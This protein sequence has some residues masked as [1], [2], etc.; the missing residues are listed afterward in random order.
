[1]CNRPFYPAGFAV[2]ALLCSQ[3][4]PA[5]SKYRHIALPR[6]AFVAAAA[7][8][9][10]CIATVAISVIGAVAREMVIARRLPLSPPLLVLLLLSCPSSLSLSVSSRS[11]TCCDE[12]SLPL[13]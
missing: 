8:V 9:T 12:I 4:E 1:M 13:S 11:W 10:I 6:R 2:Q 5:A 7:V 3:P